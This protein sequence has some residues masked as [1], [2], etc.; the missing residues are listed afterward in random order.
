M[1]R[2]LLLFVVALSYFSC[3]PTIKAANYV[4]CNNIREAKDVAV[5]EG[6]R[7]S[8]ND[9]VCVGDAGEYFVIRDNTAGIPTKGLEWTY[10]ASGYSYN[11]CILNGIVRQTGQL[12]YLDNCY[13]TGMVNKSTYTGEYSFKEINIED[14]W[15]NV[16]DLVLITGR[17]IPCWDPTSLQDVGEYFALSELA[18]IKGFVYPTDEGQMRVQ[19]IENYPIISTYYDENN[20]EDIIVYSEQHELVI[21]RTFEA[22]KWYTICLPFQMYVGGTVGELAEFDSF[23]DGTLNFR[24]S[25]SIYANKPYLVKF[26]KERTE[27]RQSM[28]LNGKYEPIVAEGG[29]YNF[30]GTFNPT[31][32]SDGTYYLTENNT[33]KPL[34]SGGTIKAFRAY[35][36][37]ASPN[38]A[39]ARAISIDGMT[40]AIEDIVGGEELLGLPQRIYTVGGQYVGDDLN[41][42]PKGVYLVNGKKIIK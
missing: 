18:S 19:L 16:G 14:Y 12:K 20:T 35:F 8:L 10:A 26:Y 39:K 1:R 22:N 17:N 40:T 21:K 37:P 38:A 5:G 11:D 28:F 34:A 29:D 6:V 4:E 24:S 36:E 7:I 2:I 23:S 31:Q 3:S 33:I 25:N 41:A 32:P 9:A 15:D 42:L 27:L 13:I 30:I